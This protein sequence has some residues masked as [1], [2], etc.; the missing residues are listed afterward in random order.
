MF[1]TDHEE[2]FVRLLVSLGIQK[3]IAKVLVY[4]A[5]AGDVT[6]RQMERGGDLRQPEVS[7][8]MRYLSE[9]NWVR[10]YDAGTTGKGR[11]IRIYSLAR[12]IED[13]IGDIE[14][15]KQRELQ[16]KIELAKQLHN[17]V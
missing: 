8:A 16:H 1:F 4:L 14:E 13:I 9:R 5:S 7:L 15:E 10:S 6:S 12:P 2:E 11:P 17:Y 3:N